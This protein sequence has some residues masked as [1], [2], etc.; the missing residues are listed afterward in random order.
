M[1]QAVPYLLQN[2]VES[3]INTPVIRWCAAY[4]LSEIAKNSTK[5]Q[6]ELVPRMKEIA[7]KEKNSGV[8]AVHLKA[9]Q[10]FEPKNK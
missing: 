1:V 10:R 3:T 4:A 2:T 7:K 5:A 9:L 6:K 8:K